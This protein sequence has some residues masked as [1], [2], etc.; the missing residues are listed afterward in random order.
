MSM[1]LEQLSEN[2]LDEL[3]NEL[4]DLACEK[5]KEFNAEELIDFADY[6]N[7]LSLAILLALIMS[8]SKGELWKDNFYK[9]RIW[10][11]FLGKGGKLQIQGATTS[12][13]FYKTLPKATLILQQLCL[14]TVNDNLSLFAMANVVGE[15][16]INAFYKFIKNAQEA[17]VNRKDIIAVAIQSI[18]SFFVLIS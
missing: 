15:K 13:D 11:N 10:L 1:N 3:R 4:F 5:S 17:H 7:G 16:V 2:F 8:Y 12:E 9:V 18:S 6:I 14:S